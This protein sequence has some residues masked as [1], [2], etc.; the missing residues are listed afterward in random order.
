MT[1]RD[2]H[3]KP[4]I[5][6]LNHKPMVVAHRGFSGKAPENTMAAFSMALEAGVA[7]IEL[8]VQISQDN[9]VVVI[10]DSTLERTTNGKGNVADYSV[11]QLKTL[12]AGSWFDES[13]KNERIPTLQEALE[14]ITP[15]ALVNVELKSNRVIRK[16]DT[17]IA[18]LTLALVRQMQ[19]LDRVLFSS[20]NHKLVKYLKEVEPHAHVGVIFHPI[21][22]FGR[23][24][25]SLA[26][27]ANAEVFV[28]S[29]RDATKRRIADARKH[30]I[31]VGVYGL[32]TQQ[33]IERMLSMGVRVLVSDYPDRIVQVLDTHYH[34]K[35][36]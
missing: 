16:A 21:M 26:G 3:Q 11:H 29:K 13:F 1:E 9:V 8:D 10:H 33:D 34:Q 12:D 6:G 31:I 24:P 25:S 27:P 23:L 15:H 4:T 7:M 32:E 35:V 19:L 20:F 18:D 22:H 17:Y 36:S 14:Y 28:C 5:Q 2:P 30:G